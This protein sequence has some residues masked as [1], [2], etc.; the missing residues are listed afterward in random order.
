MPERFLGKF[1]FN[2]MQLVFVAVVVLLL[3]QNLRAGTIGFD[4][5]NAGAGTGFAVADRYSAQGIVF[6]RNIPIE[7]V[8]V[9]EPAFY[10]TF[11]AAGGTPT[12]AVALTLASPVGFLSIDSTFV[13]PG[14]STAAVTDLVRIQVFDTEV[15]S[16]LGTLL[17]YNAGNQLIAAATA[18]TP[19]SENGILQVSAPGIARVEFSSDA[20]GADFDNL[21]FDPPVAGAVPEPVTPALLGV[22]IVCTLTLLRFRRHMRS[23]HTTTQQ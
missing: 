16:T 1:G 17:A 20:D 3:D 14:T 12:N 4:D 19:A 15:G 11:V 21:F 13:V 10:S 8:S 7:N 18:I 2:E 5:F 9:V 6:S 22:G 23:K